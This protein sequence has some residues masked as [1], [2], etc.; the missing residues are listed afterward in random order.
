[1]DKIKA[2]FAD[3]KDYIMAIV[4]EIIKFVKGIFEREFKDEDFA[5]IL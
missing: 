1:M 2:F 3:H 5:E 4:D